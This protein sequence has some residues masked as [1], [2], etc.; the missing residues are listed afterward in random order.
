MAFILRNFVYSNRFGANT[1]NYA[2]IGGQSVHL[3]LSLCL[4]GGV[5]TA[6]AKV[7]YEGLSPWLGQSA[8]QDGAGLGLTARV[9]LGD[10]GTGLSSCRQTVRRD[11]GGFVA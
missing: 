8:R 7:V 11:A 6:K 1:G 4:P 3:A 2:V 5:G 9:F 10:T